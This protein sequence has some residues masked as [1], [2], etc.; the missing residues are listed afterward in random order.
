MWL[1]G[2]RGA[3]LSL[4]DL[5]RV[6][7][8]PDRV[9][10]PSIHLPYGGLGSVPPAVESVG[11]PSLCESVVQRLPDGAVQP[12]RYVVALGQDSFCVVSLGNPGITGDPSRVPNSKSSRRKFR[13]VPKPA[14]SCVYPVSTAVSGRE[15]A[16]TSSRNTGVMAG[17]F[18]HLLSVV[19]VGTSLMRPYSSAMRNSAT[20][21][22]MERR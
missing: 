13:Q 16:A 2:F 6:I 15:L 21:R 7:P 14:E 10:E 4:I 5:S 17:L 20:A 9:A 11:F 1:S 3:T 12:S 18:M 19:A 8:C 22:C